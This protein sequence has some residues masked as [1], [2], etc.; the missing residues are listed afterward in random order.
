MD[1]FLKSNIGLTKLVPEPFP[2]FNSA[3]YFNGIKC[4]RAM[5]TAATNSYMDAHE[6]YMQ[7]SFETAADEGIA[8][9]FTHKFAKGIRASGRSGRIRTGSFTGISHWG[10]CTFSP[11]TFTKAPEELFPF[12][13]SWKEARKIGGVGRLR[14]HASDYLA[15]DGCLFNSPETFKAELELGVKPYQPPNPNCPQASL[16]DD[17]YVYANTMQDITVLMLAGLALLRNDTSN[18]SCIAGLDAEWNQGSSITNVIQLSLN[19]ERVWVLD[20]FSAGILLEKDV[21]PVTVMK[22]FFEHKE[23]LFVGVSAGTDA[24]RL[25]GLGINIEEWIELGAYARKL[26]PALSKTKLSFLSETFLH[27]AVDKS[28]QNANWN[29][30]PLPPDLIRYAAIDAILHRLLYVELTRLM[31][32]KGIVDGRGFI[33]PPQGLHEG[34]VV[35]YLLFR[36]TRAVATIVFVGGGGQ[37]R[38]WGAVTVGS[39]KTLIRL[40]E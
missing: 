9:E 25:R 40:T 36:K 16:A 6:G 19:N 24:S 27:V 22:Q 26:D 17:A 7:K 20:L 12:I 18:R 15:G 8:T 33:E 2:Q 39:G 5:M 37:T 28:G 30:N 13:C 3:G 38:R 4:T 23:L 35:E 1:K 14:Y 10:G 11:L 34:S 29:Q 31:Q 32:E 21:P